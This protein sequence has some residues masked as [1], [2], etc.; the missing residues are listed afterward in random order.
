M[1]LQ[2]LGHAC[3]AVSEGDYTV[4][5]DPFCDVKG[6]DDV[7][8][9][10]DEVLCSHSHYDHAYRAGVAVGRGGARPFTVETVATFHDEQNGAL[11]GENTVHILRGRETVVHLGD[12][13]HPLTQAQV[14]AIRGCDVLLVPVGGTY[15]VDGATAAALV[16]AVAP[17]TA[18]P[19][20][21]RFGTRGFD[22]LDTVE[23]FLGHFAAE[24]VHRLEGDTV[25]VA[26]LPR[27]IA[28]LQ[29]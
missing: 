18:I 23:P 5:I 3:F 25:E 4:V 16:R 6:Y 15:T 28:V 21:Y 7:D 19:M 11:R 26:A 20:H 10:A 2:W 8:T 1:K 22:E 13:G 27:G 9:A 17:K 12:L 24:A 29:K 14:D